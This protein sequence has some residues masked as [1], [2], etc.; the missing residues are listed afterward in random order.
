MT[1]GTGI[2]PSSPFDALM[3]QVKAADS[4]EARIPHFKALWRGFLELDTWFFLTTGV[5]DL[6]HANPFIGI[7]DDR[8]WVMVFTDPEKAAAFAGADPRFRDGQGD[9]VF[10]AIPQLE[11]LR[12]ILGLQEQGIAGL[13]INQGEFGW[14]APL[15]NLPAIVAELARE[16]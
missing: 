5:A 4:D 1:E 12:W 16:G 11:A 15:A 2:P 13:R 10:M 3:T 9:L 7:I 8:P 6:E 14:F